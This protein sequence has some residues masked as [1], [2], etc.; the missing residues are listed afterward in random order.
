MYFGFQH[1]SIFGGPNEQNVFS[2]GAI[3]Y[4]LTHPDQH[5]SLAAGGCGPGVQ[6]GAS[7]PLTVLTSMF[8]HGSILHLGGNMLFMW[9]FG[10]NVEDAMGRFRFVAFY[11]LGGIAALLGQVLV[12]PEA[13]NP[14][15]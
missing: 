7:T 3:P 10:N 8:M 5:C 1:G 4:E 15:I 14:T 12:G 13:T 9:I 11:L 2:Y 6:D